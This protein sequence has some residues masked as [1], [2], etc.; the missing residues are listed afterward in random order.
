MEL[1]LISLILPNILHYHEVV[2]PHIQILTLHIFVINIPFAKIQRFSFSL[3]AHHIFLA[4]LLV[5]I[6]LHIQNLHFDI[7][8]AKIVLYINS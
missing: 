7:A 6:I 2:T 8:K 4:Y 1:K 5:H 3:S